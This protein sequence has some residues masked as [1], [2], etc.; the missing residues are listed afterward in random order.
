MDIFQSASDILFFFFFRD[1][2]ASFASHRLIHPAESQE[3]SYLEKVEMEQSVC[4][5]NEVML[6]TIH[7]L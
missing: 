1:V 4:L 5:S 6:V 2:P 3:T 7:Q